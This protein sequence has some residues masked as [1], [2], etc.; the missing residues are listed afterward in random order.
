MR[1]KARRQ[2]RVWAIN[3]I[4]DVKTNYMAFSYTKDNANGSY[5]PSRSIDYTENSV[6]GLASENLVRI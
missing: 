2:C 5:Y 1:R 3:K 6:A 4:S